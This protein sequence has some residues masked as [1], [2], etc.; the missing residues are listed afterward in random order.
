MKIL[1]TGANGFIGGH[2]VR[3]LKNRGCYVIGLDRSEESRSEADE[4][5]FCDLYTEKT[6]TI[7]DGMPEGSR[8]DAIVHLAADM[9]KEPFTVD[10]IRNNC[11]GAQRLLELC[12]DKGV[13][14]FVQLSSLPVI[15]SPNDTPVTESHTLR[16]P[17]VYHCTKVMQEL[18][19]NYAYYTYGVRTV[20]YRIS[21]PVGP[22][23]NPKTILPVFVNKAL[24]GEDIVLLGEGTR[25]QTY[26]HV[27]DI[28]EAIY[29][30]ILS[31]K[32]QGV[33]NL[34]S[35]NLVSNKEL[36]ELCIKLTDSKSKVVYSGTPDAADG[37]EWDVCLD[38]IHADTGYVPKVGIEEMILEMKEYF[39]ENPIG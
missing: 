39:T 32:A 22:R 5:I 2:V 31:D 12:R 11:V 33:Y 1:V 26:V 25:K 36:A 23:M 16:P 3:Y 7:L 24:A 38:K 21:A 35:H 34:A 28:A 20:S 30:A 19:A 6:D 27:N 9:R 10:V 4:Y 8:P 15:G 29:L 37:L 18:L 13:G 14:V 17:T